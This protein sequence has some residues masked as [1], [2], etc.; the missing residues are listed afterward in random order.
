MTPTIE[1]NAREDHNEIIVVNPTPTGDRP[2][3]VYNDIY[4]RRTS[5]TAT[6]ADFKR[7]AIVNTSA[8][9]K[10]Y[11]V[12]SGTSYDYRVIGRTV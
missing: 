5:S 6:D 1:I 2:E 12:K 7:I 11:A 10:D 8:S 4:K 9:Y 3:V